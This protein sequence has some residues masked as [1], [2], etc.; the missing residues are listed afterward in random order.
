MLKTYLKGIY[1]VSSRGDAR[2]ESY[3]S[4]LEGFLHKYAESVGKNNVHITTLPK[5]TEA[6]IPI[7][8]YGIFKR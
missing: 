8:E 2:E 4:V 1:E 3:Y 5:K 6:A 7:L